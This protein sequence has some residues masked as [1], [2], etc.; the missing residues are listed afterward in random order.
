MGLD[1]MLAAST[2]PQWHRTGINDPF[3]HSLFS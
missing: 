1:L 3:S 2:H